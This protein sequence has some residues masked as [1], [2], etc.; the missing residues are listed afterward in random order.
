MGSPPLTRSRSPRGSSPGPFGPSLWLIARVAFA[1]CLTLGL[2]IAPVHAEEDADWFRRHVEPILRQRCLGCHSHAAGRMRGGLTLDWKTGWEQGG[3]RGPAIVPGQVEQSLL[4]RAVRRTE[5][6]LQM[7]PEPLP[8]RELALLEEWVRRGAPDPR[9]AEPSNQST[10]TDWWSLRPLVRPTI[11]A[12]PLADS[13]IDA[14]LNT[15]AREA[16]VELSAP[17][18]RRTWLRRVHFDLHGLPPS[19]DDLDQFAQ[20]TDPVAPSRWVDRLLASPRHGERWARHWFD[21]IHFADSHGFEHDVFR[22]NAWRFRDHVIARLNTDLPW[23]DFI[24]EQLAADACFPDDPAR[25]AALGFLGAGTYDHSAAATAP[26]SFE[27]LDRDDMVTQTLS[28]FASTTVHCARCHDHKFDPVPQADYYALQAVFAGLGKGE[29]QVDLDPQVAT[30]RRLWQQRLAL[31]GRPADPELLAPPV[32]S[33]LAP[34]LQSVT[35]APVWTPLAPTQ[36]T[37]EAGTQ[38]EL[39]DDGSSLARSPAPE[40]ETVVVTGSTPLARLTAVRLDVLTHESLPRLGPGRAVNGNLHLSEVEVRLRTPTDPA[41]RLLQISRAVADHDQPGWTAAHTID[42]QPATAWGVDPREGQSH[43]IV[44]TLA[45]ALDLPPAAQLS[46]TLRQLHGRQHVLGRFRLALTDAPPAA[47]EPWPA[48]LEAL[49]QIPAA[50]RS[51]AQL[52]ELSAAL[53]RRLAETELARLPPPHP[54]YAAGPVAVNERGTIRFDKPREIHLLHRGNLESPRESIG[55]GALSAVTS[56]P[57]RFEIPPDLPESAR[58]RALAEWLAHPDHPLTWRSLANRLWH[59]HFGAGLV[60]TPNDF[61][62]MGGPP[63]HPALLEWLA[64]ELRDHSTLGTGGWKPL[65]RQIVLSQAYARA[66]RPTPSAHERDPQNRLL[67]HMPRLRLDAEGFHDAVLTATGTLDN[68]M[69]GPGIAR[70]SSRPGA[71]LTPILDYSQYDWTQPGAGRRAI[72][73]VVWRGIPDPLFEALDFPDLGLLAPTRGFSASAPQSLVL[74]N[75]RFVLFH[76]RRL[77]T[78]APHHAPD[79]TAQIHWMVR[80]T[81]LRDP[82][83]EE[84]SSL[85]DL[86][87]RHQLP[88]VARLLF[89]SNE[90]LFLD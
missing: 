75:N 30:S 49:R 1:A 45:E 90:F 52:A 76:A 3:D 72:Y 88:A 42:Q 37:T 8:P 11:P 18:D 6:E 24:R 17:A 56:L 47:A 65:H 5:P 16:D 14:F 39:L 66:S 77:A 59:Y 80:Q 48:E 32:Q 50:E 19:P 40:T 26:K 69:G 36:L 22:P 4:I 9:S 33:L 73:R 38:F 64:C 15:A 7:P 60:D 89:N 25:W 2:H 83:P 10:G 87:T 29:I 28:A 44:F 67:T 35:S 54:L 27:L 84:L 21:T 41:G 43:A 58:R 82:Q 85:V 57:A 78:R 23:G 74:W 62:R 79:L 68:Q 53:L 63:S 61:G 34:V 81:W 46:V 51:P 55:P 13:P 71:Q 20:D 12:D 70:F 31:A 86:A